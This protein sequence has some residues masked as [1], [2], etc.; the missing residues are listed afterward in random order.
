MSLKNTEHSYGWISI[1]L[2][3]LVALVVFGMFGLG[4]YMVEL[5]YYDAWYKGSLDLHKGAGILL[6]I[7]VAAR[8]IWRQMN[9]SPKG[10]SEKPLENLAGHLA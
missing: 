7:A 5:T 4:L 9:P 2:H 8:I 10:L 1:T 6:A 3:W